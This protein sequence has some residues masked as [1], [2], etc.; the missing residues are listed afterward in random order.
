[1]DSVCCRNDSH[2]RVFQIRRWFSDYT[3]IARAIIGVALFILGFQYQNIAPVASVAI[4]SVALILVLYSITNKNLELGNKRIWIPLVVISASILVAPGPVSTRVFGILIFTVY[5]S[6][7]K[8]R[9]IPTGLITVSTVIIALGV[10]IVDSVTGNRTGGLLNFSDGYNIAVHLMV[11]G[12]LLSPPKTI[13]YLVPVVTAGLFFTGA[14][15]AILVYAVIILLWLIT[16]RW[17]YL[18]L[19]ITTLSI[20]LLITIPFNTAY[21]LWHKTH[22]NSALSIITEQK[23]DET[24]L[25]NAT[26]LRWDLDT[27]AFD[28][29]Q[30]LGHGYHPV[31]VKY[32]M[33]NTPI[34]IF[35]ELNLI[36]ALAWVWLL[37]YKAGTTHGNTRI[38]WLAIGALCLFDHAIWTQLNPWYWYLLGAR[39]I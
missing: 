34:R 22:L 16:K 2:N 3:V 9:Y 35:Y 5:L 15:E 33:H 6:A 17:K 10:V 7:V 30:L 31:P 39:E 28:D 25:N 23:T 26:G 11:I 1:M 20:V 29:I 36:A 27:A 21:V 32:S 8:L 4:I 13:W 38:M 37:L 12:L 14:D 24:T 19:S 18:V